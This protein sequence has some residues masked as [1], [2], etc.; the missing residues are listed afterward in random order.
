MGFWTVERLRDLISYD[1]GR[2]LRTR[3]GLLWVARRSGYCYGQDVF[4]VG[5]VI[6]LEMIHAVAL[7]NLVAAYPPKPAKKAA[8][9]DA[10]DVA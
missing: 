5:S 10:V 6:G 2:F 1:E 7:L 8:E 3:L 4:D 9:A